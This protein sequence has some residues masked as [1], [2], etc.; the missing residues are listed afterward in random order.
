LRG[1]LGDTE[2]SALPDYTHHSALSMIADAS[3]DIDA[4]IA[5]QS[6]RQIRRPDVAAYVAGKLIDTGRA[7]EALAYLDA[8]DT[9]SRY[10]DDTVTWEM[11]SREP[12]SGNRKSP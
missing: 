9:S 6:D 12:S 8:A 2:G 5:L 3:D 10:L 4:Y 7:E 11:A 1:Y